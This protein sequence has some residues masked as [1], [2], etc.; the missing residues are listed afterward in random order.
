MSGS[1]CSCCRAPRQSAAVGAGED[2]GT[3]V[4]P[5][6]KRRP[7]CLPHEDRAPVLRPVIRSAATSVSAHSSWDARG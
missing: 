1:R 3:R 4:H 7:G 6:R 5:G 2:L